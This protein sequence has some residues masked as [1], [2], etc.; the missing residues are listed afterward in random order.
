MAEPGLS[1]SFAKAADPKKSRE[2]ESHFFLHKGDPLLDKNKLQLK[3]D[4]FIAKKIEKLNLQETLNQIDSYVE[5]NIK[6]IERG[7]EE[8]IEKGEL[9][10]SCTIVFPERQFGDFKFYSLIESCLK[11]YFDQ[12]TFLKCKY[13]KP[14][15][16]VGYN[17]YTPPCIEILINLE[18]SDLKIRK[19]SQFIKTL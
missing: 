3:Y 15:P 2:F 13:I 1:H 9:S 17:S 8:R 18:S 6:N 14:K 11:E 10:L 5:E 7:I 4:D 16:N 12:F 19:Y